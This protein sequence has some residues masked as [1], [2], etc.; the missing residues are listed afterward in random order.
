MLSH[1][2]EKYVMASNILINDWP[3]LFD[4]SYGDFEKNPNVSYSSTMHPSLLWDHCVD[5]DHRP[6]TLERNH[7]FLH[8]KLI[9]GFGDIWH[10]FVIL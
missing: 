6:I 9:L 4:P 3:N 1:S 2:G 10:L 8:W 5:F 7:P